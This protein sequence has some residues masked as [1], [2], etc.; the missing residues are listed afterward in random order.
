MDVER[1]GG[2]CSLVFFTW[3]GGGLRVAGGCGH[4]IRGVTRRVLGNNHVNSRAAAV[5]YG[6]DG[7]SGDFGSSDDHPN[8]ADEAD[9]V[10]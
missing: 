7:A 4:G 5:V 10:V 8:Q 6:E 2:C 9:G 1:R 3:A